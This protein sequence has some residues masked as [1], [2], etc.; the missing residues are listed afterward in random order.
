MLFRTEPKPVAFLVNFIGTGFLSGFRVL[1][2]AQ[3]CVVRSSLRSGCP[4]RDALRIRSLA[5]NCGNVATDL[6]KCHRLWLKWFDTTAGFRE[7]FAVSRPVGLFGLFCLS[8]V[9][10]F[11]ASARRREHQ[12]GGQDGRTYR[13][14]RPEDEGHPISVPVSVAIA[15]LRNLEMKK[16]L[17][18]TSALLGVGTLAGAAQAS[19]GIKLDVGGFFQTVY[20]G[21]FDN[22]SDGHFG[23][24]R[25][26]D[27]LRAQRRSPVQG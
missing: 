14:N 18:G 6:E 7:G 16:V 25:N 20:Q 23:N 26:T 8:P 24:H 21:V 10:R 13:T 5:P 27:Q 3:S 1:P 22:K 19:D 12:R 11:H 2:V 17:L 15:N 4:A 9:T